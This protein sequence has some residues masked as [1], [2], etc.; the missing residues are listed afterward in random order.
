MNKKKTYLMG[1]TV[2]AF[3][4]L[5][6]AF[7]ENNLEVAFENIKDSKNNPQYGIHKK[8]SKLWDDILSVRQ[9]PNKIIHEE[10]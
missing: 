5:M 1:L 10:L 2:F 9:N 4:I 7:G 3:N 8:L 6:P